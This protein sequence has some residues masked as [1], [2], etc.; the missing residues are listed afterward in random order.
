LELKIKFPGAS[1]VDAE[2]GNLNIVT[3]QDGTAPAPFALFLA[4][5]GTC[6]GIYVKNFCDSR[7]ISAENIEIIQKL[8]SDPVTRMISNI[9]LDINLPEDF[10]VKYKEAVI[11]AADLCA[12]KKHLVSP[13]EINVYANLKTEIQTVNM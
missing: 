1:R 3:N 12:V 11:R 5:I 10:P 2:Y 13:P 8:E 4:S 6:A 7:G 9:T